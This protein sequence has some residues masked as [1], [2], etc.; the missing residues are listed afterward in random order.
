MKTRSRYYQP[1]VYLEQANV[2]PHEMLQQYEP[3][4]KHLDHHVPSNSQFKESSTTRSTNFPY[5]YLEHA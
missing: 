3:H 1:L 4:Q 5:L 2:F